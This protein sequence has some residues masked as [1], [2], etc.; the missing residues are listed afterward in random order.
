M[1][2]AEAQSVLEIEKY[3][4]VLDAYEEKLF[5]LKQFFQTRRF[6]PSVIQSKINSLHQLELAFK[7]LLPK[8]EEGTKANKKDKDHKKEK[9]R[10]VEFKKLVYRF[11]NDVLSTFDEFNLVT[12]KYLLQVQ[13]SS[14]ASE[15]ELIL[16]EI[17]KIQKEYCSYWTNFLDITD[18]SILVSKMPDLMEIRISINEMC[19]QGF[20]HF[21]DFQNKELM[22][23]EILKIES[24]RLFLLKNQ[25]YG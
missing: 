21:T 19:A 24:K 12:N 15:I 17:L 16:Q 25:Y 9:D 13:N 20:Y 8:S 5:V 18:E 1:T 10:K 2:Q 6:I 14:S 7:T 22:L 23:S 11:D 3:N 4:D